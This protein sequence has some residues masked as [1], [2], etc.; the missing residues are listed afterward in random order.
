[1]SASRTF[2]LSQQLGGVLVY[3]N[4]ATGG[5]VASTAAETA[6][7]GFSYTIP[8]SSVQL[9]DVFDVEMRGQWGSKASSP[10][11]LNIKVKI[12]STVVIAMQPL[13][14]TANVTAKGWRA[15]AKFVV[16]AVGA[17]GS[18]EAEG[19]IQYY[20]NTPVDNLQVIPTGGA[21]ASIDFTAAQALTVTA[22]WGTSDSANT[23]TLGQV[24]VCKL[25]AAVS[26]NTEGAAFPTTGLYTGRKFYRTDLFLDCFY[27]G[28][29]WLTLEEYT[30]P[31]G[32]QGSEPA[33]ASAD[34]QLRATVPS[35]YQ[36]YL[37]RMNGVTFVATTNDGTK[38]WTIALASIDAANAVISTI[39]TTST[40]SD[41]PS[42]W[43]NKDVAINA[44]VSTS[45][46]GLRYSPTKVSTAGTLQAYNQLLYRKVVT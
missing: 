12:G 2:S 16:T 35:D 3:S 24:T 33:T 6:F 25:T 5:V 23:I 29:R 38:Y 17:S 4:T 26:N 10:G 8:A 44:L 43:V 27:D 34:F 15:R 18:I 14:V 37:T 32:M 22:T 42:N 39:L 20:N 19:D 40:I 36:I 11:T 13:T 45:A 9:G 30:L 31:M 21:V 7:S 28:T 46:K 1:M 41:T